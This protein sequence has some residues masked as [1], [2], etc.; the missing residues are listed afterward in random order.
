MNVHS[1]TPIVNGVKHHLTAL[2]DGANYVAGANQ[3]YAQAGMA[4]TMGETPAAL[5]A[6]IDVGDA[7]SIALQA[8]A[9]GYGNL[10]VATGR[11]ADTFYFVTYPED[12]QITGLSF[13]T[14]VGSMALSG[15]LSHTLD[16]P[17]QINGPS[18]I[19]TLL[20]GESVATELQE[21]YESTAPGDATLGY[22]SFDVSQLQL[23]AI[24]F[25][26]Q[27][28]GAS[29]VTLIG[30]VGYTFIHDFADG[31]S[32]LRFGR[33]DIFGV[34]LAEGTEDDGFV[35]ES[36]WGYRGRLVANYS[37]AFLGVNLKPTLAWSHDVKGYAPQPGGNFNEGQKSLGLSLQATY[38]E[39]YNANIAYT[40]YM[41]G[42]YSVISD[43]DFASISVGMQF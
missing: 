15:E 43:H 26:N 37:D 16:L 1:R 38:L 24:Q 33:S 36:S 40:Q 2:D 11:A 8:G 20:T 10:A 4:T 42:D 29:R 6:G 23:T 19:S 41:G 7:G 35:T 21:A 3:I 32:D 5:Q 9:E 14:N 17:I 27:V 13:A 31:P 25:F 18:I 12:I 28:A 34:P 30:E 22:R 39:T